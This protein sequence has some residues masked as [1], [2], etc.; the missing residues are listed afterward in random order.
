MMS[1]IQV[2]D[3]YISRERLVDQL[4]ITPM[5]LIYEWNSSTT[6]TNRQNCKKRIADFAGFT[7]IL[8]ACYACGRE[9]PPL[10]DRR[11][12]NPWCHWAIRTQK[13][14]RVQSW[15]RDTNEFHG[16]CGWP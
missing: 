1:M 9:N 15:V 10:S 16:P 8:H 11:P 13:M 7:N 12:G 4:V 5:V 6:S 2:M 14:E 3:R